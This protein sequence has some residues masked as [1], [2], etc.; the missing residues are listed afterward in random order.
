MNKKLLVKKF[1]GE[2]MSITSTTQQ[3][4]ESR[5]DVKTSRLTVWMR[6]HPVTAYFTFAFAGT[7]ALHLP[8]VLVTNALEGKEGR[9]KLFRRY[10]QWRVGLHVYALAFL[11]F[12][13]IFLIA[14]SIVLG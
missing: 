13:L 4:D 14:G 6:Q 8:M 1:I 12:P 3:Y 9:R 11:T 7:W 10:R 2:K 5:S